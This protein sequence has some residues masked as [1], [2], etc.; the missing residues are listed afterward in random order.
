[1]NPSKSVHRNL[2]TLNLPRRI[3][4]LISYAQ[5]VLTAMTNNPN[6][7][8][9]TPALTEVSAAIT[10]LQSAEAAALSRVKGAVVTRNDKKAA[11]V[12]VLQE[13]RGYIQKVADT[14]A[15]NSANIITSSGLPIKKTAVHKPRVFTAKPGAVSGSVEVLAVSAGRRASYEWQYS[16]D[17]GKTWI[18]APP[19]LQAKTTISG[20]PV[21][22]TVQFRFRSVTKAGPS[23]WSQPTAL[24]VK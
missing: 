18:E 24:L 23:D 7:P 1:L 4:A 13:V 3:P 22:S 11:L 15:D 2:V 17:G 10:A 6:F 21:A 12:A 8:T 16:T 14:N 19:S 9:P 20:L 5:S